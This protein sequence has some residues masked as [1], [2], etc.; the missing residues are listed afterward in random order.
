MKAHMQ[1][2]NSKNYPL[3]SILLAFLLLAATLPAYSEIP[4]SKADSLLTKADQDFNLKEYSSAA[5]A[6]LQLF[7]NGWYTPSSLLRY[8]WIKESAGQPEET[9][10][11]LYKYYLITEDQSAYKKVVELTDKYHIAGYQLSESDYIIKQLQSFK[12]PI[13][14][15]LITATLAISSLTYYKWK[16]HPTRPLTKLSFA[17]LG[18]LTALFLLINF[19]DLPEKA[20]VGES[21]TFMMKGPSAA[22][23][24]AQTISKGDLVTIHQQEDVWMKVT[25]DGK[26]GWVK[27]QYLRKM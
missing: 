9:V 12:T 19:T 6:Y 5:E 24:I 18:I 16:K 21:L 3:G 23:G 13:T 22:A 7:E 4:S 26:E 1:K 10:F 11:A 8:A 20:V 14:L 25:V 27:G 2:T 15:L 17:N